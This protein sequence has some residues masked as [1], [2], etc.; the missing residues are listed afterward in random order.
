MGIAERHFRRI[1]MFKTK[2]KRFMTTLA[3]SSA[4]VFTTVGAQASEVSV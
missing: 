1:N 4:I 3:I 2:M